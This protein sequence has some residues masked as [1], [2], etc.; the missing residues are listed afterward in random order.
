M[1]SIDTL[2][3]RKSHGKL[4]HPAPSKEQMTRLFKLALRAPDHALLKPWRFLVFE[5]ESL[6][7]LGE[8]MVEASLKTDSELSA[9]KLEKIA[10]KP[11]RAPMVVISIVCYKEHPKVPKIEQV[12]SS[13]ASVQNLLLAAHLEGIG[14]KWRTGSLAFNRHLMDNLG[15]QANEQITGFIYLG[16]EEG[17]KATLKHPD[18]S[19]FVSWYSE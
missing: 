18:Q 7:K 1:S 2:L 13:G 4:V 19:E 9:E 17:R 16:Q 6:V 5:G 12:L 3:T 15:L 8:L 14:V 10:N 11:L